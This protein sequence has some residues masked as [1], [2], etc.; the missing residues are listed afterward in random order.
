MYNIPI[1]FE[2]SSSVFFK[3]TGEI[4]QSSEVGSKAQTCV[5]PQSNF[6][7]LYVKS[8]LV[9]SRFR[10]LRDFTYSP[11]KNINHNENRKI[12][13]GLAYYEIG[14][15]NRI[16]YIMK[17]NIQIKTFGC[18]VNYYDSLLIR[19]QLENLQPQQK[20]NITILNSCAVTA[21][22]GKDIR[23]EAEKIKNSNPDSLIVVTGCGA[24]VETEIYA[25][26]K[27]V[28]LVIGNSD[29]KNLKSILENF[30][31]QKTN[32]VF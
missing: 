18:K 31:K 14:N 28:D 17:S 30:S 27:A 9:L 7:S 11:D 5:L 22:A 8:E 4:S 29:K 26:A 6:Q 10:A 24:Q 20:K 12:Q 19:K 1:R 16:E 13:T 23:K 32:K 21:Q 2:F 15:S 25:S 3:Q